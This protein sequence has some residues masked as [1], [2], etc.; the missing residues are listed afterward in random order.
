[1]IIILMGMLCLTIIGCTFISVCEEAISEYIRACAEAKRNQEKR[2]K[3]IDAYIEMQLRE[4]E[5]GGDET[6]DR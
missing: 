1:M 6:H 2:F 4:Q 5:Q 3:L